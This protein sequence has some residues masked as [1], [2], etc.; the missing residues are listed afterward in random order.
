MPHTP[1]GCI[2]VGGLPKSRGG[3]ISIPLNAFRWEAEWLLGVV[4]QLVGWGEQFVVLVLLWFLKLPMMSDVQQR[5]HFQ[6]LA[7]DN[8]LPHV[9]KTFSF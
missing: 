1:N 4:T 8:R 6:P 2:L 3:C 9:I 7:G 5:F